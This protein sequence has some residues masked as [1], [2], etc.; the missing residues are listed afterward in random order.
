MSKAK[1]M[2]KYVAK[3]LEGYEKNY[4]GIS[5]AIEQMEAQMV[6][7]KE[8]QAQMLKGITEMKELLGLEDEEVLGGSPKASTLNL[9]NDG[10]P[11]DME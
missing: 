6:T 3:A 9:V 4:E 7:Y 8:Q 1:D 10:A 11:V 5:E 2:E